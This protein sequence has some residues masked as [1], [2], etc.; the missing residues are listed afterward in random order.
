M[1]HLALLAILLAAACGSKSKG[2]DTTAGGGGGEGGGDDANVPTGPLA[3]GQWETLDDETR[4]KFM[5][6]VVLPEMKARFQGFDAE[7]FAEFDCKTCHGSGVDAGKFEMPNP[8]L[9]QLT[10]EK[11]QNPDADHK[12]ITEFMG[13]QVKPG[14]ATLL[15][16]PEYSAETPDGF[17]CMHCHTM[18]Q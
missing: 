5:K 1:K 11:I 7:E 18:E 3:A 6:A 10:M 2:P 14:M 4:A 13:T 8:E 9:P 17:G 16:L 15:G 12:A